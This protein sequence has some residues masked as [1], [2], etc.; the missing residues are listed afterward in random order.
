MLGLKEFCLPFFSV[1]D[2]ELNLL[3]PFGQDLGSVFS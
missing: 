2:M 3:N 1:M